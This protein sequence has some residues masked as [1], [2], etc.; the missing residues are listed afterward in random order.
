MIWIRK[1]FLKQATKSINHKE[2]L[3]KLD[4]IKMKNIQRVKSMRE[5]KCNTHKLQRANIQKYKTP[6]QH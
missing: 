6:I 3:I 2:K 5:D 1:R 4:Y